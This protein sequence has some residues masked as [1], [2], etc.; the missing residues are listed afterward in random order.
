MSKEDNVFSQVE[1]LIVHLRE[2]IDLKITDFKF[3]IVSGWVRFVSD[4]VLL[5]FVMILAFFTLLFISFAFAYWFGEKAD[6]YPLAFLITGG[7]WAVLGLL[8]YLFR[9]PLILD[10]IARATTEDL[11]NPET[12]ES[13]EED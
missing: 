11:F 9:K 8:V 1:E 13:D 10:H 7:F 2:Y 4:I 3:R 6:N 12:E 5:I